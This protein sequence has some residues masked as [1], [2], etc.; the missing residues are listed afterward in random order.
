MSDDKEMTKYGA[1][2]AE[3]SKT[4][5]GAPG[6]WVPPRKVEKPAKPEKKREGQP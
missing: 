2:P 3:R 1:V 4:A 6:T 5:E